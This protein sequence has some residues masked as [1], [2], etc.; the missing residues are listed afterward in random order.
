MSSHPQYDGLAGHLRR[1]RTSTS[2]TWLTTLG[3]KPQVTWRNAIAFLIHCASSILFLVFLNASQPFLIHQL[4]SRS[5]HGG[6]VGVPNRAGSLSGSL[7]F[8]DELLSTFMSL[9]WGALAELVG[10]AA[11]TSTSYLFIAAGLVAY[12]VPKRPWPDLVPARLIFAVGGSG[13]TAMLSGILSEYSGSRTA[14]ASLE[15]ADAAFSPSAHQDP[16]TTSDGTL[17]RRR[18]SCA[19]KKA[20][21]RVK[22]TVC[23][24]HRNNRQTAL[25]VFRRSSDRDRDTVV[26]LPSRVSLPGLER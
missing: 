4:E 25:A 16:E 23:C 3:F 8:Y 1:S 14:Q 17:R 6:N 15:G 24:R 10:L 2:A 7:I 18:G 21:M 13:A 9:I 26:W 11:V 20:R 22:W 19:Q 12:T 5:K